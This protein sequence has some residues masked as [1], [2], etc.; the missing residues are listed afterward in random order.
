MR[1]ETKI[2]VVA[3]F[4]VVVAASVYFWKSKS[5][6]RDVIVALTPSVVQPM[7]IGGGA[8]PPINPGRPE[9][10]TPTPAP[11]RTA[12]A[13]T[14]PPQPASVTQLAK[15]E[16][17]KPA[18]SEAL[19][20]PTPE[21]RSSSPE[22]IASNP[23]P[24]TYV[25]LRTGP[26]D[27]LRMAAGGTAAQPAKTEPMRL[28]PVKPAVV[29]ES[30]R[31]NDSM[32]SNLPK[33]S[34]TSR[35]AESTSSGTVKLPPAIAQPPAPAVK[36]TG[37]EWKSTSGSPVAGDWP[38]YHTVAKGETLAA[39]A[40]KTYGDARKVDLIL[41]ANPEIKNPRSVR[42]GTKLTLPSTPEAAKSTEIAAAPAK[43]ESK[44]VSLMARTNLTPVDEKK[45]APAANPLPGN[46]TYTVQQGDSLYSIAVETLGDGRKWPELMRA[47]KAIVGADGSKIRPGMVL[48]IP[49]GAAAKPGATEQSA[50][51]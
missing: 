24:P 12:V 5:R 25:P 29:G 23:T 43:V 50:K 42:V 40:R 16:S 38:K 1:T 47:N 48:T 33:V 14:P 41:A 28:E 11:A 3:G 31:P 6:D 30:P 13:V 22:I 21:R 32:A 51:R 20:P 7:Q 10:V 49:E 44:P 2:G 27:S 9:A 37:S 35:I 15:S 46:K 36:P 4:A 19:S 8:R 45:D 26:S 18:V 34:E 17:P 39:I